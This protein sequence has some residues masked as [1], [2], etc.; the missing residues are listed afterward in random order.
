MNHLPAVSGKFHAFSAGSHPQG[1]VHPLALELLAKHGLP[2]EGLRSKSW[3]EF[4]T[5]NAPTMDFVFTV[6][7]HAASEPCPTW[8]G[9]PMTAHWGVPD[10]A[11]VS[12][13]D[14]QQRKAFLDA[15]LLLKRRIELFASLPLDKLSELSLRA[16]LER[17]GR[18]QT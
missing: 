2:V 12:G 10:P 7:D 9:Q 17:I 1:Q 3:G 4:A 16:A 13:T 5:R 14:E 11:A 8:P 6:C 15:Y 18:T